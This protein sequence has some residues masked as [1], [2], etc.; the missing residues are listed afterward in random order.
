[1]ALDLTT[2]HPYQDLDIDPRVK[3]VLS[4]TPLFDG[5]N[6]LPQQPRACF[7][8]QINNNPKFDL[9]KGFQRGMTDIPRLR[10]G[11]V[12]AQFWSICVPCL[13]S[14]ENFSTPEYSDMAR[15]AIEQIDLTTRMVQKYPEVFE[16][17]HRPREVK[18]VLHMAGNSIGI[19]RA[20]YALGVRYIYLTSLRIVPDK[21]LEL[22]KAPIMFSH[23]NAK[24]VFDCPRNVP[25]EILDMIPA[26]G[27]II[28]VTFV[29]EHVATNRK[30]ANMD[31]VLDHLFYM[32]K[33]IGWD[34]VGLGSDFD[35][36]AS[37]I[38]GLDD[39]R[40]Y[41]ALLKAIL[42]RGASE[43][44]LRKV[45]GEN[46]IRVWQKV[47]DVSCRLQS[48]GMLPVEDVWEGRQWWRYDGYYQMP[49]PDPEDELELDWYS[50]PPPSEGLYHVD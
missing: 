25:D 39:V 35:G 31:M 28:M 16:L 5:H 40:C 36:I 3:S 13:R 43:E 21:S 50:V 33:R 9:S 12:G 15:D 19:I 1:M 29:P 26:N 42:D 18:E 8:G 45:A 11:A 30:H 34:H 17:V 46:M 48:E 4:S 23:S 32:A 7:H 14:A 27:G 24:A 41:P 6:D 2:R 49:D 44:Q 10:E 20:F 47:E 38:P 22:T 37:V